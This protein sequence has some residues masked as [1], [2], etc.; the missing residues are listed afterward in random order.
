M[1]VRIRKKS[2][3]SRINA[4]SSGFTLVLTSASELL[5]LF[6]DLSQNR[7]NPNGSSAAIPKYKM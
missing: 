7:L 1:T 4:L 3:R 5:C 2:A 6:V